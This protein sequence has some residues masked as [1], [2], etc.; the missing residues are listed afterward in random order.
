MMLV[1]QHSTPQLNE[2]MGMVTRAG[3]A[4]TLIT[5]SLILA[6]FFLI[7][8]RRKREALTILMSLGIGYA[9]SAVLKLVFHRERP[10]LWEFIERP[11][12][13]SFPSGHAMA[14][15]VVY[16]MA[17]YLLELAFPRFRW[18]F[19]VLA[20]VLILMIGT[21]RVYLG[22]HWPSDVLAGFVGGLAVVFNLAYWYSRRSS[23]FKPLPCAANEIN[24]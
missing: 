1:H 24:K 19:R 16:G 2:A 22:V 3:N 10:N 23:P 12:D 14:S 5:F 9:A 20:A 17:A 6:V 18:F 21:S 8:C 15:M 13:Y 11:E 4:L 7:R